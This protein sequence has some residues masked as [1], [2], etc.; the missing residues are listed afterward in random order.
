MLHFIGLVLAIAI[1]MSIASFVVFAGTLALL[2][3]E[4]FMTYFAKGYI[5]TL[6]KVSNMN[7]VDE[8]EV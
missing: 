6:T 8:E 3:N 7:F 5:K 4:K 1:G 2:M